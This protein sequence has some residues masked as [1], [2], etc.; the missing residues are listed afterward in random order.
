MFEV[1]SGDQEHF[2]RGGGKSEVIFLQGWYITCNSQ[3]MYY[4]S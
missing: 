2:L 4:I 1:G 3:G